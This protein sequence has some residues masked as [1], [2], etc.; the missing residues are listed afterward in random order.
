MMAK[1]V[2]IGWKRLGEISTE[3]RG[4]D[5]RNFI[6]CFRPAQKKKKQLFPRLVSAILP[7]SINS[8]RERE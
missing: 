7:R 4:E 8:L 2:G 6:F 1:I 3:E 5:A